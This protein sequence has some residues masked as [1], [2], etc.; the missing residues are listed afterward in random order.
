[1]P[2]WVMALSL[3]LGFLRYL[4]SCRIWYGPI[5]TRSGVPGWKRGSRLGVSWRFAGAHF[6]SIFLSFL[7]SYILQIFKSLATLNLLLSS[8]LFLLS[9]FLF[10]FWQPFILVGPRYQV[11]RFWESFSY[12]SRSCPSWVF[13]LCSYHIFLLDCSSQ[14]TLYRFILSELGR[15]SS[16][17]YFSSQSR[18]FSYFLGIYN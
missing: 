9:A 17:P 4:M 3:P 16:P 1:M 13:V 2:S 8:S 10:F 14:Y 6:A 15:I 11:V 5:P 18:S 12:W 7:I